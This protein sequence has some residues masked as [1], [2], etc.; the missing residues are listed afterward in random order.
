MSIVAPP[1]LLARIAQVEVGTAALE[2]LEAN[3]EDRLGASIAPR[4]VGHANLGWRIRRFGSNDRND[5]AGTDDLE[6]GV[7]LG[8]HSDWK[9][10]ANA[11][12]VEVRAVRVH[13]LVSHAVDRVAAVVTQRGVFRAGR[14]ASCQARWTGQLI[15]SVDSHKVV[16]R[17]LQV[18]HT[19]V[20]R[21]ARVPVRTVEAFPTR[22]ENGLATKVTPGVVCHPRLRALRR[23]EAWAKDGEESMRRIVHVRHVD[24][25]RPAEIKVVAVEAL[26]ALANERLLARTA[27]LA[28][29]Q[30]QCSTGG[31]NGGGPVNYALAPDDPRKLYF[32]RCSILQRIRWR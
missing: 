5:D 20:A 18:R 10:L 11:A 32:S 17:M 14:W 16:T 26:V 28:G 15:W 8:M 7:R 4:G 27:A 31:I 3:A 1:A 6:Q 2:A 25:A 23:A 24:D 13:A 30:Q 9:R 21:C 22:I 19:L 12:E 29:V